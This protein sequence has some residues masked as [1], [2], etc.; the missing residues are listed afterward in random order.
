MGQHPGLET[1]KGTC[2][3]TFP[4]RV[5]QA[6]NFETDPKEIQGD[7][8]A[9][10]CADLHCN[11]IIV[12]AGGGISTF[13]HSEVEYLTPNPY[14]GKDQDFFREMVEG[15]HRRGIRVFARN[16]YG[17]MSLETAK[18]HPD[19]VLRDREGNWR[20]VYDVV[21]SCPSSDMF[22]KYPVQ[23]FLEQIRRYKV[24]GIYI[25]SLGGRCYCER[26]RAMFRQETGR[27]L[28]P[29][30]DWDDPAFRA[31]IEWGY[32]LVD[33]I[34]RTQYEGVKAADPDCAYFIDA[35][36]MQAHRWIR[37]KGQDLVQH[38][39]YQSIVST[40]SFNDVVEN[41]PKMLAPVVARYV[42]RIGDRLQRP[43]AVF[44][45]SFPGHSWPRSAQPVEEYRAYTASV[46]L[47]GCS[48][49]TPWYGHCARDDRRI[50]EPARDVFGFVGEHADLLKDALPVAPV[51][52]VYSRRTADYYGR[53][54]PHERYMHGLYA[55]CQILIEEHI[56]FRV[57]PDQD[58]EEG[59]PDGTRAVVLPNTVCLSDEACR[60]LDRFVAAG[61][62][63]VASFQTGLMD[64]TGAVRKDFG[65]DGMGVRYRGL[66]TD[67]E[68]D[69]GSSEYHAY[70]RI[71]DAEHPVFRG[72]DG[73]SI[74][75]QKGPYVDVELADGAQALCRLIARSRAQPPEKGWC[76]LASEAPMLVASASGRSL[77][78][79][80]PVFDLYW[81]YRLSDFRRL[82]GNAV[83]ALTPLPIEV[84]APGPVEVTL[85]EKEGRLLV[86]LV[87][88]TAGVLRDHGPIA[89]GPVSVT[90]NDRAAT[91][92][93]SLRG[94]NCL[95]ETTES[96]GVVV[97][98]DRLE[99]FDLLEFS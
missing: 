93:R 59:L 88:H 28:P 77:Y 42:R 7:A 49:I 4:T 63:V 15:C 79:T 60:G 39:R 76:G 55:A 23:A 31:W 46:F 75:P 54:E 41:Y 36:G 8:I 68:A 34:A 89:V 10:Q 71:E 90:L 87:N 30:D 24:D 14:L 99:T 37:N 43:G 50:V 48:A 91:G 21:Y 51:A 85:L 57:I 11:A 95:L 52:V 33:R 98:L 25:N 16:D 26:C 22:L 74:L 12:D 35:A 18:R 82:I 53:E 1:V 27:E 56:P 40:E 80:M 94:H 62:G 5:Y 13:Y 45:S 83:R 72:F 20:Q 64:E 84:E 44:V 69:W 97:T 67:G 58:L 32:E 92:A 29:T 61:G 19:W 9:Q 66:E 81:R 3:F 96:Q 73:T 17:N 38:G 70:L 6:N 65:W 2:W 86:G 47:N 78:C